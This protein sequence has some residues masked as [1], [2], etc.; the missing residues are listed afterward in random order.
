[1]SGAGRSK[2]ETHDEE[3]R[4]RETGGEEQL[5]EQHRG[6]DCPVDVARV[7]N[8]TVRNGVTAVRRASNPL[9]LDRSGTEVGR[10]GEA[11]RA[12]VSKPGLE[13]L[14]RK[15]RRTYYAIEAVAQ[16]AAANSWKARSPT[17]RVVWPRT[18]RTMADK[19]MTEKTA[20]SQSDP[21]VVRL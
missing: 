3:L 17:G 19:A 10:H 9:D 2:K 15:K 7:P 12:H 6:R 4:E 18:R 8:L 14:R 13:Y 11:D 16:R 5:E 20:Q 1:M 21:C